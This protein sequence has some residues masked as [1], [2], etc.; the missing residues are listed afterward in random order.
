[1]T[2]DTSEKGLE[3]LIV[4]AMTGATDDRRRPAGAHR[5]PAARYGGMGWTPRRCPRLPDRE[6]CVDL[7]SCSAFLRTT[8]PNARR[9][10]RPRRR[11]PDAAEVPRPPAGRDQQ[12]R[13]DR[14]AAPRHQARPAPARP[15]LRH[16]VTGNASR[17]SG[18][19]RT[20]S[21]SPASS[22][23]AATRRSSRSTWPV[24]Q[25][26]AGRHLRAEEQPDQADG[27]R[28]RRAVQ[29]RPRPARAAVRV[30]PLRRPL[31]RGRRTRCASART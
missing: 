11:Q 5:E 6:Y 20:A 12:A 8:Q 27:R 15:V 16:A 7:A 23:T 22:A 13:R 17:R 9:G 30:R 29:A 25:R 10:A 14:R 21:A 31:R 28:R 1:M 4:A 24:H 3:S 19:R 2:T 18:T 26:P